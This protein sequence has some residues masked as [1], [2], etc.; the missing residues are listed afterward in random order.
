MQ[1]NKLSRRN[2]LKALGVGALGL[3]AFSLGA[4]RVAAQISSAPGSANVF[5]R[6]MLGEAEMVVVSTVAGFS[7]DPTIF[8]A[9]QPQED[10][11]SFFEN[12]GV[13]RNGQYPNT[14]LNLIM[15][16]GGTTT[17]FDTGLGTPAG[18]RLERT[19]ADIGIGTENVDNVVITHFHPDHINGLSTDGSLTFPNAQVFMSQ[20]EYD[21]LQNAPEDVAGNALGRL[22][23]ALDADRVS[24]YADGDEFLPGVTAMATPGH[25]P[26]HMSLMLENNGASL[27][28]FVDSVLNAFAHVQNPGWAAAFDGDGEQAVETRRRVLDIAATDH[29]QVMGYHFPFPGLGYIAPNG[30]DSYAYIPL[31][32]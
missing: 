31:A 24:F 6:F 16:S 15:T 22:Q 25:T 27:F 3:G 26:G 30:D 23:P 12:L 13:L 20:P 28:H 21:F 10:V 32:T 11:V 4:G 29:I 7:L 2:M 8:G 19:I 1:N 14:V 18:G 5:Y 17:V 9:N